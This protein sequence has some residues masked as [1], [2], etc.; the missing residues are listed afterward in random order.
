[1]RSGY[2]YSYT[3]SF[4]DPLNKKSQVYYHYP[5]N[6]IIRYYRKAWYFV[7]RTIY[8]FCIMIGLEEKPQE[9]E[10]VGFPWYLWLF[11]IVRVD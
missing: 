9:G 11:K 7:A 1:M 3:D 4:R 8:K 10:V 2:R 5:L 6:L